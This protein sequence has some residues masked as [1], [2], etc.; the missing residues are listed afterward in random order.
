M[1]SYIYLVCMNLV[2]NIFGES[3]PGGALDRSQRNTDLSDA[4]G[5][6]NNA[7]SCPNI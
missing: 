2:N 4:W 6:I 5:E 7:K 3:T 1:H